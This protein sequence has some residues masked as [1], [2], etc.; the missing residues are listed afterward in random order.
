MY[1]HIYISSITSLEYY[2]MNIEIY[3]NYDNV[4]QCYIRLQSVNTIIK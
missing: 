2:F 3:S 4:R 1:M